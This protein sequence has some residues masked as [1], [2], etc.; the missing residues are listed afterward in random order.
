VWKEKKMA[1][2]RDHKD[3]E[4]RDEEDQD[5]EE[6][7]GDQ[8][9]KDDKDKEDKEDKDGKEKSE[10]KSGKKEKGTQLQLPLARVKRIMKLDKD[11]KLISSDAAFLIAKS[12]ELFLDYLVKHASVKTRAEKRKILHYKDLS[13]IA[14]EF[15]SLE[16]L[17]DI[18]PEK[19]FVKA[20]GGAF[21]LTPKR[22]NLKKE[23]E[24]E[25]EESGDEKEKATNFDDER[26]T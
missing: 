17:V 20:D 11:V 3:E 10:Q 21:S 2:E 5:E 19:R 25:G 24:E 6:E 12:A 16:F 22:E 14:K 23:K 1:E 4:M 7:K 15:D 18:I 26:N 9:E 8:E 13:A